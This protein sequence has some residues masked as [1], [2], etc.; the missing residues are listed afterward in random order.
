MKYLQKRLVIPLA[1]IILLFTISI[2]TPGEAVELIYED[3]EDMTY[4]NWG[5]YGEIFN[6]TENIY[7][8]ANS[9]NFSAADKTL[10]VI[11]P[12]GDWLRQL[13]S[14]AYLNYSVNYGTWSFDL[15]MV[16]TPGHEIVIFLLADSIYPASYSNNISEPSMT[17]GYVFVI[18]T[19]GS[20]PN[21]DRPLIEFWYFN[22]G[23]SQ[24]IDRYDLGPSGSTWPGGWTHFDI[25]RNLAGHFYISLN[26]TV[27]MSIQPPVHNI[28]SGYFTFGGQAGHA[29]D[30]LTI[31]DIPIPSETTETTTTT[32]TTTELDLT[33]ALLTISSIELVVIVLLVG[34]YFK[35]R[36]SG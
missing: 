30:N 10:K 25:A 5:T 24:V 17:Y 34:L 15:F 4:D 7:Y 1:F 12:T 31:H 3:F 28:P 11:G 19:Y 23:V 32:T 35:Q 18:L 33:P 6:R 16:D 22:N 21:Y 29:I 2:Q 26:G 9:A 14:I 27:C 13:Y 8:P 20:W 36:K